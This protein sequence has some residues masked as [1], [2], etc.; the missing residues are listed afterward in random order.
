MRMN[1]HQQRGV[2]LVELLFVV[3]II[4]L[5]MALVL[6]AVQSARESARRVECTNNI[7]Q[8]AVALHGYHDTQKR[9]P[10]FINSVGGKTNRMASW[11]IMLLP[12]IDENSL[13]DVW[14][15]AAVPPAGTNAT[16]PIELL[17]CAS[18][19]FEESLLG[20]L[21]YVAN[22]G[23]PIL[24]M[25]PVPPGTGLQPADGVFLMRVEPREVSESPRGLWSM[26]FRRI[27]DGTGQT[28]MLSENIQAGEY[29]GPEY[30]STTGLD[31][32]NAIRLVSD[33][34][35][36]TGFVWD[37]DPEITT[38]PP[39]DER[40][41][42]GK[43]DYGPR[44]PVTSYYYS[45]PSSWHPGG[46]NAAMCDAS[47]FFLREDIEYKVYEQLMTSNGAK[48]NMQGPNSDPN[49]PINYVLQTGDYR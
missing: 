47:V 32:P 38:M 44:A 7:R 31:I 1:A 48:S 21:S 43:K 34:Q 6:P 42:N 36:L 17:T 40:C 11:P 18:D 2:T 26:T 22:C 37:Y 45:R 16:P 41:I 49:A 15:R 8:L 5:L 29:S 27:V 33:A 3:A 4:G 35:L 10:G 19:S 23:T 14:N 46:V 12:Y 20:N 25:K 30:F 39:A 24:A 9:L 13:W 28:L